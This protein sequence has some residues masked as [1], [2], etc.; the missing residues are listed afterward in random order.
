MKKAVLVVLGT[1]PEAIKLAPVIRALKKQLQTNAEV[2]V[3]NTGQHRD[4]LPPVLEL[5]R[6]R[7]N[8]NLD[9]MR[10]SQSPARSLAR[11]IK[12]LDE[13]LT[14]DRPDHVIVQ[15][16][17]NSTL[18]GALAAFY[19]RIP[20]SHVEAGLRTG[21]LEAPFPEEGNRQIIS[22]LAGLHFAPTEQNRQSLIGEGIVDQ[23]I[24]VTGNPVI[25]SLKHLQQR[26][27]RS[28]AVRL[29]MERDLQQR[30]GQPPDQ[31][32]ILVTGHRR[33]NMGQGFRNLAQALNRIAM[34]YPATPILL[35]WHP[36]P[37]VRVDLREE[38][39]MWPNIRLCS[40]LPYMD[41]VYTLSRATI[42]LTDSGGVQEEA[43]AFAKPV[44]VLR[45]TTERQ[46]AVQAGTVKLVGTQPERILAEVIKLLE[47]PSYYR[48]MAKAANPYGDGNS[49]PRIAQVV[50]SSLM[51]VHDEAALA[52]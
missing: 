13:V 14:E 20:V 18:A 42:V 25:D 12:A 32:F 7:P 19:N 9:V 43:P 2:R 24:H 15:G 17:T 47:Q 4:L 16:D 39:E 3:C 34:K 36:N 8:Y 48:S 41:F 46:E 27:R 38:L 44:L 51:P 45:E 21:S 29:G 1:R 10:Q 31:P 5:F 22:R 50:Q 26:W 49:A 40:P 37:R 6:I 23:T 30:L 28:P 35:P 11:V 33:E 52:G